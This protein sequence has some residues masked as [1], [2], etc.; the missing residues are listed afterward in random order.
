M[1]GY[2][3]YG[4]FVGEAKPTMRREDVYH[5]LVACLQNLDAAGAANQDLWELLLYLGIKGA[6]ESGYS[7]RRIQDLV[8]VLFGGTKDP[9]RR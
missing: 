2:Y 1:N 4:P 9:P 8:P 5:S 7:V 3:G 6:A